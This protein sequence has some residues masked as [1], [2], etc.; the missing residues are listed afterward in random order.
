MDS[1][2][3]QGRMSSYLFP[4]TLSKISELPSGWIMAGYTSVSQPIM[5][6]E[7]IG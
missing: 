7:E 5:V 1:I 6:T 4:E 2:H 3:I